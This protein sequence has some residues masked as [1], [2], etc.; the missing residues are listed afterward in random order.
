MAELGNDWYLD[1]IEV[2]GPEGVRW[3]FPC[4]AWLGRS[5]GEDYDGGARCA[6]CALGQGSALRTLRS[7][8]PLA[9]AE[10]AKQYCPCRCRL[11]LLYEPVLMDGPSAS[12]AGQ[13]RLMGVW[14]SAAE[15]ALFMR[16]ASALHLVILD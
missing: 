5:E 7:G 9:S 8:L 4:D 6:R 12:H 14:L 15:S 11:P 2:T 16:L 10:T 13:P 3:S 1:R